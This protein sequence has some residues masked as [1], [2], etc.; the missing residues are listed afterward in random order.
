[1][2]VKF[3]FFKY[4][5]L[6]YGFIILFKVHPKLICKFSSVQHTYMQKP[7]SQK[8]VWLSAKK[9]INMKNTNMSDNKK[10]YF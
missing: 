7:V 9:P 2:C 1:M 10:N 4:H 5:Y 8:S 6:D 3:H